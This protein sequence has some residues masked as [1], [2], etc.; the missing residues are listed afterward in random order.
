[1]LNRTIAPKLTDIHKIDFVK[2]QIF[3][4]SKNVKLFFM[5]EVSDETARLDLYFNAGT[6]QG[7]P[8]IASFVNGLLLSGTSSKTSVQIHQE[9]DALGGFYESGISAENAVVTMYSLRDKL[10]PISQILKDAIENLVFHE[11]EVAELL[12]DRRQKFKVNM[13]K[14][15]FLAQRQF[16]KNLF[17]NPVYGRVS[18]E[19]DFD[20][21]TT[22]KL[23]HFFQRHYLQGLTKIVLV[24]NLSQDEVDE[25]I[26]CFGNWVIDHIPTYNNDIHNLPGVTHVSKEKALQT[27]I[28]VGKTLFNKTHKDY[29]DFLVL[30]TILG[31]YFG[32][33]L[34]SNIR[35][36]KGFTYGIGSMVAELHDFGYFLIAT[37]VGEKFKDAT[38]V[39]I[40][41]EIEK[42]QNEIVTIEELV[43][44][45]NYMLGQL[46]KSADGPYALIDLYMG[47]EPYGMGLDFYNQMIE[48]I[49][50]IT[51]QRIQQLA[52]DYLNWDEMTIVSAG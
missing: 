49:N 31:D 30:N 6:T 22:D 14:V 39:E 45:K 11:H 32:S 1:M 19:R 10:L 41:R 27:A 12:S 21:I 48:S 36:E 51:P 5:Q 23:K 43:L 52:Q 4:V 17:N 44:V 13:E 46:L 38:F 9:I 16:Q 7:E 3:D 37:E 25:L 24:G 33:R 8:A 18:E 29:T 2:P 28:R 20:T 15:S 50:R 34:M 26:D 42:I 40:R 35:E 47:V